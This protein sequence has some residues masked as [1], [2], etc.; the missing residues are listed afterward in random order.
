MKPLGQELNPGSE[1]AQQAGCKC[2]VID[3]HY[4]EGFI[5]NGERVFWMSEN[6]PLHGHTL[7]SEGEKS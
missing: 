3:N 7:T 5:M 2:P 1:E 4:G 6:C